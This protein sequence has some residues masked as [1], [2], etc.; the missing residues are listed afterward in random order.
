MGDFCG[1]AAGG[2]N[3]DPLKQWKLLDSNKFTRSTY[4]QQI[5]QHKDKKRANKN[6]S[7]I[8]IHVMSLD[9]KECSRSNLLGRAE[10][11]CPTL[12]M[13]R[14]YFGSPW[15]TWHL[16]PWHPTAA[17]HRLSGRKKFIP[18]ITEN[19]FVDAFTFHILPPNQHLPRQW[20]W[21]QQSRITSPPPA[22]QEEA[23]TMLPNESFSLPGVRQKFEWIIY[24]NIMSHFNIAF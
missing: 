3:H 22:T 1:V 2:Q 9:S 17:F 8:L 21:K 15:I 23:A 20:R 7:C 10:V 14:D 18:A 24:D 12:V 4:D 13:A 11:R 19:G 5:Y 6:V 16:A